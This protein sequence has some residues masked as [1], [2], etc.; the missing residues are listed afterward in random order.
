MTWLDYKINSVSCVIGGGLCCLLLVSAL[1]RVSR[2]GW[3]GGRG[4]GLVCQKYL[5]ASLNRTEHIL[6]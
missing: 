2:L 1:S 6:T 5:A 4:A 3:W